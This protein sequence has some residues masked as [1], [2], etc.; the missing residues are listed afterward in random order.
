[1]GMTA[2]ARVA[3]LSLLASIF[4]ACGGG[5][6]DQPAA[7]SPEPETTAPDAASI[8]AGEPT[9]ASPPPP[10]KPS[11]LET[12]HAVERA[13]IANVR[14]AKKTAALY[15]PDAVVWTPGS[16]ETKGREAIQKSLEDFNGLFSNLATAD[17]R[18][19][20][21]GEHDRDSLR[22]HR[23]RQGVG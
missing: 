13:L 23:D 5:A 16:P 19:W 22:Q 6:E 9:D 7:Q 21:R 4:V 17:L 11:M 10:P 2:A 14:D 1:M 20:T 18:V 8:D 3:H 12:Q 15:A